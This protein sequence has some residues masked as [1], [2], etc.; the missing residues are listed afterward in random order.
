MLKKLRKIFIPHESNNYHPHSTR[1]SSIFF[2]ALLLLVLNYLVFPALGIQTSKAYAANINPQ[3]LIELENT[4]RESRGLSK[5]TENPLL[6]QAAEL[7]GKDMLQKQYWSHFG[8]S[9]ETPWQFIK[10]AGYSYV[11]AGENLAK[12]FYSDI[13]VHTAW[14]ESESHRANILNKN[15]NDIGI[16]VVSGEFQGYNS[17]I[18]VVMFG[19]NFDGNNDFALK[20]PQILSPESGTALNSNS[21]TIE[22]SAESGDTL[23]VFSNGKLIGELPKGG[24]AFTVNVVIN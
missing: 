2:Y 12:D 15:F 19:S 11:Y 14:M 20:A 4:E 18:I 16:A 13:D 8:P 10:E 22:G 3:N 1:Y 23:K 9:N 6:K 17:T 24:T 7:K 21:V 5:L